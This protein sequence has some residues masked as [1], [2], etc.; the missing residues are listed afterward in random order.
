MYAIWYVKYGTSQAKLSAV[1]GVP[2]YAS[3]SASGSAAGLFG[4]DRIWGAFLIGS[5]IYFCARLVI[6]RR[7]TQRSVALIAF[8]LVFWTMVG[9]SRTAVWEPN[10]SRY[11][12]VG[13]VALVVGSLDIVHVGRATAQL[14]SS[15]K[16]GVVLAAFLAVWG[17]HASLVQGAGRLKNEGDIVGAELAIVEMHRD[18][19]DPSISV[20]PVHSFMLPVGAYLSAVDDLGSSAA[21]EPLQI[22]NASEQARLGADLLL[23]SLVKPQTMSD[24]AICQ[25]ENQPE[26]RMQLTPGSTV[27]LKVLQVTA[28]GISRFAP[29]EVSRAGMQ[30]IEAGLF[31]IDIPDD[32]VEVPWILTFENPNDV[33]I[34]DM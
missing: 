10:A 6:R 22:V 15:R 11:L 29:Q 30:S 1:D 21:I 2:L 17:S 24:P 14:S 20:D 13:I 8:A 25:V 27:V 12:Y 28:Y 34:C 23:N 9:L 26:T 19:I 4:V 5:V 16:A 33:R 18:I 31:Q 3:E 7:L 32:I